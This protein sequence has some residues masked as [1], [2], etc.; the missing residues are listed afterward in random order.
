MKSVRICA[1]NEILKFNSRELYNTINTNNISVCGYGPIMTL[2]EYSKLLTGTPNI[3]I[4][5]RGHS[6]KIMPSSEVVDY[7][8]IMVYK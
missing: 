6:G 1:L 2:L 3:E 7:V 4:L 5:S 8:S